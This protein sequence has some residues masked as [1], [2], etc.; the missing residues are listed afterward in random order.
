MKT[1]F[2]KVKFISEYKGKINTF[3]IDNVEAETPYQAQII[4]YEAIKK[5]AKY[6][7]DIILKRKK[8][9]KCKDI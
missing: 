7:V 1:N 9:Q 2:Y 5:E 3:S 8:S 4:A 6:S